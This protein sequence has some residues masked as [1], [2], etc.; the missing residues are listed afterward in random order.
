MLQVRAIQTIKAPSGSSIMKGTVYEATSITRTHVTVLAAGGAEVTL[1]AHHFTILKGIFLFSLGDIVH[2][3]GQTGTV[4]RITDN[5]NFNTHVQF[6]DGTFF[7]FTQC[8]RQDLADRPALTL[9]KRAS[10]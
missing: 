2:M 7:I 5:A 1:P 10:K 6:E 4:V 9:V 8:G 3:G